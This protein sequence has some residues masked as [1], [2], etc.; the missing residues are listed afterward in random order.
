MAVEHVPRNET[1]VAS[2]VNALLRTVGG[3][4]SGA[5]AA[6]IISSHHVGCTTEL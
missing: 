3:C 1:A 6:S 4:I 2:G 5:V